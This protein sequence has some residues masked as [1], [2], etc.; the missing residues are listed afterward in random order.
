MVHRIVQCHVSQSSAVSTLNDG[1]Y[2]A[3]PVI[4]L[5][6]TR[7]HPHISVESIFMEPGVIQQDTNR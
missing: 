3:S 4:L 5:P 1:D 2:N 6:T 7:A